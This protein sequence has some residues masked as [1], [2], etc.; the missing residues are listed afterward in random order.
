MAALLRLLVLVCALFAP[1]SAFVAPSMPLCRSA[2]APAAAVTMGCRQNLKK[3]KRVRNRIN[4][5]RFKKNSARRRCHRPLARAAHA[6]RRSW[7]AVPRRLLRRRRPTPPR[8]GPNF[9]SA[10]GVR[11]PHISHP[12][13]SSRAA[14]GRFQRFNQGNPKQKEN[15]AADSEFVTAVFTYTA[16]AAAAAEAAEKTEEKAAPA[17]A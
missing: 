5:F 7:D 17:A 14:G 2:V 8:R 1:A 9:P 16:Q 13:H 4:A 10:H 12:S 15:E 11:I 6:A 3:E